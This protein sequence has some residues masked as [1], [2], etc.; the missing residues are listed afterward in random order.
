MSMQPRAGL[1][2]EGAVRRSPGGSAR[3]RS[4]RKRAAMPRLIASNVCLTCKG[5]LKREPA[6]LGAI[7][8]CERCDAGDPLGGTAAGWLNGQL[9]GPKTS[10]AGPPDDS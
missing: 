4:Q 1:L 3:L 7:Y 8:L 10:D 2:L 6:I 9:D 5:P